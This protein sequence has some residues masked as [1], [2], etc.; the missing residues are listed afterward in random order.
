MKILGADP[1]V[2]ILR[3]ALCYVV[4]LLPRSV[5]DKDRLRITAV[6]DFI[7]LLAVMSVAGLIF[8]LPFALVLT[9]FHMWVRAIGIVQPRRT[10]FFSLSRLWPARSSQPHN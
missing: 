9:I 1:L 2:W 8:A 4:N 10:E 3:I 7:S 6:L 5:L